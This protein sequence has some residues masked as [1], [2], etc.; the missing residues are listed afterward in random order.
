MRNS[1]S[2]LLLG[3]S[4]PLAQAA[5]NESTLGLDPVALLSQQ[6]LTISL[7]LP[8]LTDQDSEQLAATWERTTLGMHNVLD[9]VEFY[10]QQ[11]LAAEGHQALLGCQLHLADEFAKLTGTAAFSHLLH[12]LG[13][14]SPSSALARRLQAIAPL[15]PM[16]EDDKVR[17][18][19][20]EAGFRQALARQDYQLE[21]S[22]QA[23][24]LPET[25]DEIS[26][27]IDKRMA[28]Y[29]LK[30][31]NEQCRY[32]AWSAYQERH[33]TLAAMALTE[34][35]ALRQ[36]EARRLGYSDYASLSLARSYL[37]QP[38]VAMAFLTGLGDTPQ[39]AP[40][41]IARDL[42]ASQSTKAEPVPLERELDSIGKVLGQLGIRTEWLQGH[43]IRFW[44][45]PRLLGDLFWREE[46]TIR[47]A[48]LR[49]PVVGHQFA[50]G[51]LTAPAAIAGYSKK[52]ALIRA[53]A[54]CLELFAAGGKHYLLNRGGEESDLARL[55]SA[56]LTAWLL[57]EQ[58]DGPDERDQLATNYQRALH[59]F[60][61]IEALS[62]YG[63]DEDSAPTQTSLL[64]PFDSRKPLP[65]T[66]AHQFTGLISEGP[67]YYDRLLTDSL[68]TYLLEYCLL[69]PEATFAELAANEQQRTLPERLSSLLGGDVSPKALVSRLIA[70]TDKQPIT[71]AR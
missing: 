31:T 15:A 43:V 55:P 27:S 69:S 63:S 34:I 49:I 58:G 26:P 45:G 62:F 64:N 71:V 11:P 7:S 10:R 17:L 2:A 70:G 19:L 28:R 65:A 39:P 16:P 18:H 33:N 44:H 22:D 67:A 41:N 29:L 30:Q 12:G 5:A 37:K 42:A 56:W 66:F 21:I 25:N 24:Q 38:A 68:A 36:R 8:D 48:P 3:L 4:L 14:T 52:A 57:R 50:Q 32:Q 6:C 1:I 53:I 23:C 40:W 60:R 51:Q 9:Q 35:K 61:A 59:R 20:A 54:E 46:N 47:F 13:D